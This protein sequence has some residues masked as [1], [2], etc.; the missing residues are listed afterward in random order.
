ML[1]A[2]VIGYILI[3]V[4]AISLFGGGFYLGGQHAKTKEQ[5]TVIKSQIKQDKEVEKVQKAK[6]KREIVYRDRIQVM[7][8][9]NDPTTCLDK[10]P[11]PDIIGVYDQIRASEKRS[12][13]NGRL[14]SASTGK[15]EI[16]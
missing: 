15:P 3:L 9:A 10:P 1:Q 14:S 12:F 6:V 16:P 8:K 7:E 5:Q 4:I 11:T 2:K 13:F